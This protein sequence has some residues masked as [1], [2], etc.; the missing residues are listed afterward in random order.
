MNRGAALTVVASTLAATR[1]GCTLAEKPDV[2]R[3][4]EGGLAAPPAGTKL[5]VGL[6]VLPGL[7]GRARVLSLR[8][9]W[10]LVVGTLHAELLI[11]DL[12]QLAAHLGRGLHHGILLGRCHG[13][14]S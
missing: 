3:L 2:V 1:A 5:A 14:L 13:C 12:R 8:L 10:H 11:W 6:I 9:V 4:A 7:Q